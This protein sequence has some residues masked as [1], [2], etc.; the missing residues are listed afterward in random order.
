MKLG[1][2]AGFGE[3]DFKMAKSK[4]LSFIEICYNVGLDCR[5]FYDQL[6]NIKARINKYGVEIGSIGRWGSD[7][8]APDG[9]IIE[10]ELQNS[11]LLIDICAELGCNV[12]NTGVNYVESLSKFQ[13]LTCAVEFLQ[14]L[15]DYGKIKDVK[16]ATYNCDWNN[17]VRCPEIWEYTH[18]HI[19]DLG[20]KYDPTH[21][22]NCGSGDYLG[23]VSAWGDR[24]YHVHIKG[25]INVNGDHV[26]DPPAGLDMINWGAFIG[27][28]YA[29]HYDANLSIEPHSDT[30][31]GELSD[32]GVDFTINHISKFIYS[33]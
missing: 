3:E 8:I 16:V 32:F 14:K 27:L 29:K 25:T 17:Y 15:V 28:L 1:I 2:I 9:S 30:W 18:G 7:K 12:F 6:D 10:E 19:K 33:R 21:C 20:I 5:E 24:F 22:I 13:N 4:G 11:Y 23:E 31:R 26:D